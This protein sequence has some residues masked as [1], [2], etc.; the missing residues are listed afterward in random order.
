MP[1]LRRF[2]LRKVDVWAIGY[3]LLVLMRSIPED[4]E[5]D[6]DSADDLWEF[7]SWL[8]KERPMMEEATP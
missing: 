6:V 3:V 7:G 4:E 8:M 2:N 5:L 1:P